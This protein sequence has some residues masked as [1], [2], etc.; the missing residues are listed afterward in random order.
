MDHKQT[1]FTTVCLALANGLFAY[2]YTVTDLGVPTGYTQSTAVDINNSGLIAVNGLNSPVLSR[3]Y[4]YQSGSYS[5]IPELGSSVRSLAFSINDFGSVVGTEWSLANAPTGYF[6]NYPFNFLAERAYSVTGDDY[7]R[8]INNSGMILGGATDWGAGSWIYSGGSAFQVDPTVPALSL[9][10]DINNN[11]TM[12]AYNGTLGGYYIWDATNPGVATPW[13]VTNAGQMTQ[14]ND[15][16]LLAGRAGGNL[17]L[18]DS[19]MG[20]WGTAPVTNAGALGLGVREVNDI[21]DAGAVVGSFEYMTNVN[22]AFLY[23]AGGLFDLNTLIDP[24][25]GWTL[26]TARGLNDLGQIVGAGYNAAGQFHA[27]LL[28]PDSPVPEPSTYG[29]IG[30]AA[31]VTIAALRRRKRAGGNLE[32]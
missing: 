26:S 10:Y 20:G 7:A 30:A 22:R 32:K 8:V 14:L 27:Y 2:T 15:N 12:L 23:N 18:A 21:N 28:T 6:Y 9:A 5:A 16:G 29:L 31:L 24:A 1:L 19:T 13:L 25:L 11:G 17:V 3:G 4:V